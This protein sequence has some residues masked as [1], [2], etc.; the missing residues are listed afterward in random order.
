MK[1]TTTQTTKVY[2]DSKGLEYKEGDIVY[3][4]CMGDY[5]VVRC[6]IPSDNTLCPYQ[7]VLWDS[8]NEYYMDLDEPIG[9]EIVRRKGDKE[10]KSLLK[11]IHKIRRK[12]KWEDFKQDNVFKRMFGTVYNV[13]AFIVGLIALMILILFVPI[14]ASILITICLIV[15]WIIL[16]CMGGDTE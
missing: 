11:S 4:P 6:S 12:H 13:I 3:N 5:W 16:L 15:V 1:Y 7:L 8:R 10:Y 9:F 2:C 14:I